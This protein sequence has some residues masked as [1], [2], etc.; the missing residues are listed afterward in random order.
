MLELLDFTLITVL[1]WILSK[2][3]TKCEFDWM[4]N[5]LAQFFL[6][7]IS[8][9]S[10][11]DLISIMKS[12]ADNSVINVYY[13]CAFNITNPVFVEAVGDLM[14][15][16]VKSSDILLIFCRELMFEYMKIRVL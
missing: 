2:S 16:S 12:S 4:S 6:I 1:P 13:K 11:N 10:K 5:C 14:E 7:Y 15:A 8:M 3:P 9:D